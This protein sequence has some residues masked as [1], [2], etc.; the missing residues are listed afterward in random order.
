MALKLIIGPQ[1]EE[2][3]TGVGTPIRRS[4]L[5]DMET[6]F[7]PDQPR[8]PDGKFAEN[9]ANSVSSDTVF[10]K[11]FEMEPPTEYGTKG[12]VKTVPIKSLIP[13]Q[14]T[15]NT[16]IVGE[17]VSGKRER[18][19]LPEVARGKDGKLY[20]MDGHHKVAADHAKGRSTSMVRIFDEL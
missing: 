9:I 13:T 1:G 20:V 2:V 6:R 5:Y 15:L 11:A 16:K 14:S 7:D 8:D 10:S 3:W 12:E 4:A 19:T 17:Y 18:S